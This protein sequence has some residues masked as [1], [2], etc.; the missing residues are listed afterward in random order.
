[1]AKRQLD[2]KTLNELV[3]T[4]GKKQPVRKVSIVK[5]RK[6]SEVLDRKPS[7]N[8]IIQQHKEQ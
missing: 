5:S 3:D 6:A 2:M 7:I 1:M 8:E 4:L